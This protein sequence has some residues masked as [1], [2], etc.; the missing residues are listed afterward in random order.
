[1]KKS[2]QMDYQ[3]VIIV[4]IM[5]YFELTI[6]SILTLLSYLFFY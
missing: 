5:S 1:M 3:P 2:R 6:K 4:F